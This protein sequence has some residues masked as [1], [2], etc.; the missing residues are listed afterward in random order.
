MSL[1]GG[2]ARWLEVEGELSAISSEKLQ[3]NWAAAFARV[4]SRARWNGVPS[5]RRATS[6]VR[7]FIREPEALFW[8]FSFRRF[9]LRTGHRV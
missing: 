7:E 3:Q 5:P 2:S 6:R 9:C 1:T 8:Y 4:N